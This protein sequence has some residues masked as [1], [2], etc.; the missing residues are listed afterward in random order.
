MADFRINV[1]VDPSGAVRGSKRVGQEL[2]NVGRK[3][4]RTQQLLARAFAF[5]TISAGITASI[6]LLANFEQQMSTVSAITGA[7]EG[8]FAAL[9]EEAQ[10]LG[11]NTRFSASQAAEGMVFLARAGFNVDQ[12]LGSIGGTLKLAQAGALGLASAADIASNVLQGFRLEVKET[13]R[14]VDVLAL[15]ANSSN[16]NVEQLGQA[17]KFVAPVAAGLGV[18]LEETTAAVGALSNAGLQA[19][20][21]GTGLR[22]V[23]AELESP[24]SNSEKILNSLG[25]TTDDVKISSVGLTTALTRLRDAGLDT[26]LS[27][28]LFGQR[29]GPAFEVL[30]SSLPSVVALDKA[31]QS[32]AGT[33]DRIAAIMDDNLNGALLAVKS[34]IEGVILAFGDAGATSILTTFFALMAEGLRALIPNVDSLISVIGTL[35]TFLAINFAGKA[36]PAAIAGIKA[37]TI[38]I[39]ANP[40]GFLVT[41]L[42]LAISALIGFSNQLELTAGSSATIFDF[43]F[44]L[45]DQLAKIVG[46]AIDSILATLGVLQGSLSNFDFLVF[47][48]QTASGIDKAVALFAGLY[49]A[50]KD[51]FTNLPGVI[52]RV[53]INGLNLILRSTNE[54]VAEII[55]ALNLIPGVAIDSIESAIPELENPYKDAG[56]Q[57]GK[58]F[59]QGFEDSLSGGGAAVAFIDRVAAAA[60]DR[61]QERIRKQKELADSL[62]I[63]EPVITPPPANTNTAPGGPT[64]GSVDRNAILAREVELL[65]REAQVLRLV[66]DERSVLTAQ[67]G[68][69]EKIRQALRSADA[70]L[71]E[72]Q[73]NSLSKLT[74]KE[75]ELVA[76]LTQRNLVLERQAELLNEIQGPEEAL[77][78]RQQALVALFQEG[79]ISVGEF[80]EAILDLNVQLSALSNTFEGGVS[81]GLAKVAQQAN[82]LGSQISSV[83]TGAFDQAGDA[84]VAFARTGEISF[85]S[86]FSSIAEQLLK[87][88]ANQLFAQLVGSLGGGAG[89]LGATLGSLAAG[90]SSGGGGG[91]GLQ[92]F[93]TGGSF[94]VGGNG[95]SDSQ[96]V[97]FRATPGETVDVKTP[98]QQQQGNMPPNINVSPPQVNVVAAI[99]SKDIS[100]A[101]DSPDGETVVMNILERNRSTV[102]QISN[103]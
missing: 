23:L 93:K 100:D 58:A 56:I 5:A 45:F 26:G 77:V 66:G 98:G 81:N 62:N 96:V 48:R 9:R 89:N 103:G 18:S 15:A 37:L 76:Q 88:A 61:A 51:I 33:A 90:A 7:T 53:F 32:A 49:Q 35:A 71:S 27:L 31:L 65:E 11:A 36:I 8:Q 22:R 12:V 21:A 14:V 60:E 75:A 34:A 84:I 63:P 86:L 6:R 50:T 101:I 73:I 44:S 3:A 40:I 87:L 70:G 69:E 102:R 10:L 78:Q 92:G 29:G 38:A 30:A 28:E 85:K 94:M 47:V 91:G 2:D 54:F 16:T 17:L 59:N 46:G 57:V 24:S 19:S 25:L 39:A 99:S 68:L 67:L 72:A 13:G 1:I 43:L 64:L 80:H 97:A 20:M 55:M 4:N 74:T 95:G 52:G 82:D 42:T 41:A 83:V 79:A